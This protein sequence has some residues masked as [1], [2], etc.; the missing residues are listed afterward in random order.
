MQP[1]N[2]HPI[3]DRQK[4]LDRTL[5]WMRNKDKPYNDDTN[6]TTGKLQKI[7]AL[8]PKKPGQP[9][10]DRGAEDIEHVLEDWL[11]N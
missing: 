2:P 4:D 9:L 11:R 1:S 3:V 6:D 5:I 10:E 7:D 8:L